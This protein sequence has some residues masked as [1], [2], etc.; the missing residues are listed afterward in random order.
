MVPGL[1]D[2]ARERVRRAIELPSDPAGR[3]GRATA[4][5]DAALVAQCRLDL[6]ETLAAANAAVEAGTEMG[7]AYRV[8]MGTIPA[9]ARA[10]PASSTKASTSSTAA[11]SSHAQR[12][13]GWTT[14]TS[15]AILADAYV[16]A[17]T[18]EGLAAVDTALDSVP[19]G[20]RFFYGLSSTACGE[21]SSRQG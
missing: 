9:R 16:R 18:A 1:P 14:R 12:A 21:S 10:A 6:D 3:H 5:A 15:S 13:C 20:G 17:G 11:S 19:R 7:S 2:Q 4:F 8:A